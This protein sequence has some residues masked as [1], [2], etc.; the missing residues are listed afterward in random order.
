MVATLGHS[1]AEALYLAAS[2]WHAKLSSLLS[3]CVP[4]TLGKP[5]PLQSEGRS[6]DDMPGAVGVFVSRVELLLNVV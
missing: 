4:L 1:D 2:P 3:F 6:G 5:P